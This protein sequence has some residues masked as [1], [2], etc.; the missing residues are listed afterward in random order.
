MTPLQQI[1][2]I[3]RDFFDDPS[4]LI[5]EHTSPA[6]LPEWDS[7]AQVHI[8]LAV[9]EVFGI[10]FSTDEVAKIRCVADILMILQSKS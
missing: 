7:V 8:V 3:F 1:Q 2:S 10:R 4:I 9:E 5:T 6:D